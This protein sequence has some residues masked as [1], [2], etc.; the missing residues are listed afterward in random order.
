MSRLTKSTIGGF[1]A[2]LTL[3][4]SCNQAIAPEVIATPASVAPAPPED[5][6]TY[7]RAFL[8]GIQPIS[9]AE[10]R[11]YCGFFVRTRDGKVQGTAPRAGTADSC[12]AGFIPQNAI[13][14]YHT[15]GGYLPNYFNE[16]PS[17]DDAL[18]AVDVELD[19]YVSTPGGRLWRID[20]LTGE[21]E[22]LCGRGCLT[23]DPLYRDN[24]RNPGKDRF[25]LNELQALQS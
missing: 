18:S 7:A 23:D 6:A 22:T 1:V 4:T 20:G 12:V 25:T 8:D 10:S 21:S 13:A 11:E 24:P 9:I 14:S 3:L 19:D 2:A 17:V 5:I 16:V 15:H